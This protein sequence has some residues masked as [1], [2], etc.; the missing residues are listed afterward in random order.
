MI[1][2]LVV[3]ISGISLGSWYLTTYNSL[4]ALRN[5]VEQSWSNIE[6]EL[7]RRFDLIGNLISVAKGYADYEKE[8]L[9]KIVSMRV[10]ANQELSLN[11][12]VQLQGQLGQA[13]TKLI[14]ISEAYPDLKADK[15]FVSLQ[16]ELIETENRI[17]QRRLS[18]NNSVNLYLNRKLEFPS[19][20][21]ASLHEFPEKL[22]FDAPEEITAHV[23]EVKLS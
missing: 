12:A 9:E 20:L 10:S 7:K 18:Y 19:N 21:I 6:V 22:Y 8:T 13:V 16:A 17:A 4:V 15:Q 23:P 11:E 5:G 3:L 2:T 14:A 1:L